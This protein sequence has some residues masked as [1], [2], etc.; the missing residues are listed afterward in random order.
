VVTLSLL[1]DE[2]IV[3]TA[4]KVVDLEILYR[5]M[6][7]KRSPRLVILPKTRLERLA[8]EKIFKKSG[9]PSVKCS[10]SLLWRTRVKAYTIENSFLYLLVQESLKFLLVCVRY[11]RN[12]ESPCDWVFTSKTDFE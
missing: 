1:G 8:V 5:P 7:N 4:R 10:D 9:L 6:H 12:Q 11:G 3:V 2:M